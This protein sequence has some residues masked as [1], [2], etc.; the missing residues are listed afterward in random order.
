[1]SMALV[2]SIVLILMCLLIMAPADCPPDKMHLDIHRI[3]QQTDDWCWAASA[4]MAMHFARSSTYVR[5]CL[6]ADISDAPPGSTQPPHCCAVGADNY[7]NSPDSCDTQSLP[8]F[9]RFTYHA[10]TNNSDPDSNTDGAVL[11]WTKLIAII[12]CNQSPVVF[13]WKFS[14][15]GGHTMIA[16]GYR[17][18][19]DADGNSVNMVEINDPETLDS[20]DQRVANAIEQGQ[21]LATN[22]GL[23]P[24]TPGQT[25]ITYEAFD[26][27][28]AT[29]G[30]SAYHHWVDYSNIT[31][32]AN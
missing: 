17:T 21:T 23:D 29:R 22:A 8:D 9:D 19:L 4:E 5:Q 31:Y 6:Q 10:D 3:P 12:G 1:M 28:P 27:S 26:K 30:S 15:G 16:I 2:R 11:S 24:T 25:Y 7:T 14:G 32:P 13:A 20:D 18:V